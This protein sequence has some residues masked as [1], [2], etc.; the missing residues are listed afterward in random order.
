MAYFGDKL[1]PAF[2][3]GGRLVPNKLLNSS[4]VS[5]LRIAQLSLKSILFLVTVFS[6]SFAPADAADAPRKP[7]IVGDW[8]QVA[9]DPDLGE[10]TSPKQQP[11]D[12]SVWQAANGTWQLW[13]CIRNTKQSGNT[14]LFYHWEGRH[15]TDPNWQPLGIVQRADPKTGELAGGL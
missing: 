9:G 14:R 2:R 3:N 10:L 7:R 6:L 12:F 11:V 4:C 13:S 8:W 1:I 15:L 5:T